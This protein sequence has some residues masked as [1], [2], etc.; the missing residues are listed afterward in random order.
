M[1]HRGRWLGVLLLGANL[2]SRVNAYQGE[3]DLGAR[4]PFRDTPNEEGREQLIAGSL[5]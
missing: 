5:Q 4:S 1:F 3:F 2:L